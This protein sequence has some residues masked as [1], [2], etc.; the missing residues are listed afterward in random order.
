MDEK[1]SPAR[2]CFIIAGV[3]LA[4]CPA[5]MWLFA[6]FSDAL[7]PLYRN[8]SKAWIAL[9]A[10]VTGIVP[11]ALW[12]IGVLVLAVAAL[13]ALVRCIFKRC[14]FAL[15]LSLVALALSATLFSFVGGW[16]LNHYAP[17]LA[18]EIGLETREST[19]E[20]LPM[21]QL[22]TSSRPRDLPRSSHATQKAVS[23]ARI[24]SRSRA[25]QAPRMP[26]SR[27]ATISSTGRIPP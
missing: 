8:F 25:S 4:A 3:L 20:S 22:S 23:C 21:P 19:I 24:S 2:I 26:S 15:W 5:L 13:I 1:R 10:G 17:P 11:F 6:Q 18:Q 9:L 12:D 7:F 14:G 16:A 27:N